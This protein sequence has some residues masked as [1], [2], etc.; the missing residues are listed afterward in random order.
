MI[1]PWT[2]A[3]KPFMLAMHGSHG[4]NDQNDADAFRSL[5]SLASGI[6]QLADML[7]PPTPQEATKGSN[8][9]HMWTIPRELDPDGT[10]LPTAPHKK[11]CWICNKLKRVRGSHLLT[12]DKNEDGQAIRD[13][14]SW[15]F[16]LKKSLRV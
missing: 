4:I 6:K 10:A 3:A 9:L 7:P 13:E 12:A 5:S 16:S 8:R 2:P 15:I 11:G 1:D 14:P